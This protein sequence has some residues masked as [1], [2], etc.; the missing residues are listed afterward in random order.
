MAGVNC[1]S[2][3]P[4]TTKGP[5]LNITREDE[6][7]VVLA[8]NLPELHLQ[9]IAAELDRLTQEGWRIATTEIDHVTERAWMVTIKAKR[10]AR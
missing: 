6:R 10:S 3:Q 7:T 8:L 5:A 1:T 2:G 4:T 9:E